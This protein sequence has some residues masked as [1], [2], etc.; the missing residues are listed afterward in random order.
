MTLCDSCVCTC[1]PA[2]LL[3]HVTLVYNMA[4]KSRRNYFVQKRN[5]L[6]ISSLCGEHLF[7]FC[8]GSSF[9][10]PRL[11]AFGPVNKYALMTTDLFC[12][13]LRSAVRSAGCIALSVLPRVHCEFV[14]MCFLCVVYML[15]FSA[16]LRLSAV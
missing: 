10:L 8:F 16:S 6:K 7:C 3:R 13:A 12:S 9:I 5:H 14:P 11:A 4:L 15:Y 1:R 2:V